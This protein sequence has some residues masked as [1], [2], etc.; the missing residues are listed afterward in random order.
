MGTSYRC[1]IFETIDE[2]D[3]REWNEVCHY[4]HNLYLNPQFLKAVEKSFAPEAK[5]WYAIYRDAGNQVVAATCFSRYY[6]D[7]AHMV[8][9][10]S[11]L[12]KMILGGRRFHSG[13]GKIR[14]LLGGLPLTTSDHQ[15]AIHPDADLNLLTASLSDTARTLANESRCRLTAFKEFQPE[16]TERINGLTGNG[17]IKIRSQYVYQL[18]GNYDSF[19]EYLTSRR[20]GTRQSI[21]SSLKRFEKSGLTYEHLR[22]RDGVAEIFTEDVYRLYLNVFHRAKV[23]FECIPRSFFQELARQLPDDSC[24]TIIRQGE[25]IVGFCCGV[26]AGDQHSVMIVGRDDRVSREADLYFNLIYR[27]LDQ[28]LVPGIRTVLFGATSD[29]LKKRMGC[30]GTWLTAY[31]KAKRPLGTWLLKLATQWMLHNED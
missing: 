23:R 9:E 1:E 18:S 5:I 7:L 12:Q 11:M 4:A 3:H 15:L 13:F 25:Q 2:V 29:Q 17:Y 14:I 24:F 28:A 30:E 26:A 20:S 16:L 31:S 27:G 22:G 21:R 10:S 6:V 19:D 8:A